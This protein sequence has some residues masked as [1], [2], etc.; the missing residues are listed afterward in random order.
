MNDLEC[1]P[2]VK[3]TLMNAVERLNATAD[4]FDELSKL[5]KDRVFLKDE[6]FT[7]LKNS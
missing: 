3:K 7:F 2:M 5:R 1:Q 4:R 6:I